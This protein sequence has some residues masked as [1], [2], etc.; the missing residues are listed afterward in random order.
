MY[1]KLIK[2][3]CDRLIVNI[4][5]NKKKLKAFSLKLGWDEGVYV[6]HSI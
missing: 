4:I 5:L 3:V 1:L 6:R 2:A